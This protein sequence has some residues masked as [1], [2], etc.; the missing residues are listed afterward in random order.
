MGTLQRGMMDSSIDSATPRPESSTSDEKIWAALAHAS[1]LLAFLGPL[2]AVIL[3]FAQRK[4]SSYA[5]FQALQ[6]MI[7]QSICLWLYL[8][9][10]P[11]GAV[12]LAFA[13]IFG[14][15]L[16]A[17]ST[18]DPFLTAIVPQIF[19]WVMVFG[20]W[21]TYALIAI[22][23]AVLCL[24]G[25]DFRYPLFGNRLARFLGYDG[26]PNS[27]LLENHEDR[28]VAAVSH[29]TVVLAFFGLLTPIAVWITQQEHSAFLRFQA[30]Q[31]AIYQVLGTV[32]Y[33]AF[34]ALDLLFVFGSMGAV[35]FA[36][37]ASRASAA[38][39]WFGLIALPFLCVLGIFVL[40]LPLYHLFGF[41]ATIGVL[42]G[43]NYRYPILGRILASRMDPEE[44]A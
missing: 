14:I 16:L 35:M 34:L 5:A 27:A 30:L 1:A 26:T 4:R 11:L 21:V 36:S 2:A 7:Y 42:R 37:A 12:V 6:A 19:I 15:A 28:V 24:T 13:W 39:A 29:S 20:S 41:L 10:I 22:L 33:V 40:A 3:W 25:R 8:T 9:V 38:P 23:A 18:N 17:P 31:A 32:G 43:R 44:G